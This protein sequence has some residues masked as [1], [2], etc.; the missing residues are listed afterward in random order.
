M[1]TVARRSK[2]RLIAIGLA[3]AL[4]ASYLILAAPTPAEAASKPYD[5][6]TLA[7]AQQQ[8]LKETNAYRK[9]K[10]LPAV[11][12]STKMNTVAVNWSVKQAKAK[13][14]SHNPNY[15]KQIPKGWSAAG[16]NVAY[17]F[18]PKK[19]NYMGV[20]VAKDSNGRLYYTQVFASY[21]KAP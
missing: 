12:L 9:S 20:G 18:A 1:V 3:I 7:Q 17:G 19:V 15:S 13:K 11:K 4:I 8:I 16:E 10:G 6:M 21:S 14:M 2:E 5:G